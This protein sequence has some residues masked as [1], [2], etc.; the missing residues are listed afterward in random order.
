M[1]GVII[2]G[3]VIG[4]ILYIYNII[5]SHSWYVKTSN[6]LCNPR[7]YN[8][9][10]YICVY[11]SNERGWLV[12]YSEN[13][14]NCEK[15]CNIDSNVN[16]IIYTAETC[17][18]VYK[19]EN[20]Y[21]IEFINLVTHNVDKKILHTHSAKGRYF[22][23]EHAKVAFMR[24]KFYK[25]LISNRKFWL[26]SYSL[27]GKINTTPLDFVNTTGLTWSRLYVTDDYKT[28]LVTGDGLGTC[29]LYEFN[30]NSGKMLNRV[31]L[32]VSSYDL[33]CVHINTSGLI[34][35]ATRNKIIFVDQVV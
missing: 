12:E 14:Q 23:F 28:Y 9:K 3:A 5:T 30:S 32:G 6:K 35:C 29:I 11:E 2:N 10:F 34:A 27:M 7:V 16:S 19:I 4:Y 24:N 17:I 15:I 1:L 21:N 31:L 33:P 13:L 18:M 20:Y 26:M 25:I 22:R 8:N